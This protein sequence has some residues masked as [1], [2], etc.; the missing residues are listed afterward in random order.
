[1]TE[2]LAFL[3]PALTGAALAYWFGHKEVAL[4]REKTGDRS[5]I[6]AILSGQVFR[7]VA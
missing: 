5:V 7:G 1:M 3:I 6:T 2:A 4:L